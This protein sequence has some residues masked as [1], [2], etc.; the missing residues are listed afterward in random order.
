MLFDLSFKES[1]GVLKEELTVALRQPC[2][3]HQLQLD[4]LPEPDWS[5]YHVAIS[6]QSF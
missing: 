3:W 2:G 1:R 6:H 4:H 5:A